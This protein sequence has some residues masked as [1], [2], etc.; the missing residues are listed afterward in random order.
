MPQPAPIKAVTQYHICNNN[1]NPRKPCLQARNFTCSLQAKQ[2]GPKSAE[3]FATSHCCTSHYRLKD[4]FTAASTN[5]GG[6]E[7]HPHAGA[8]CPVSLHTLTLHFHTCIFAIKCSLTCDWAYV[9]LSNATSAITNCLT[10]YSPLFSPSFI[11]IFWYHAVGEWLT[12]PA[13]SLPCLFT[14]QHQV[15][16]LLYRNALCEKLRVYYDS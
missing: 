2:L 4:I 13:L 1:K 16:Q 9:K 7:R 8:T 15:A 3:R 12:K 14:C 10:F 6:H 11:A 5:R